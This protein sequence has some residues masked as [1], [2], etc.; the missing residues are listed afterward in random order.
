MT[1]RRICFIVRPALERLKKQNDR[2]SSNP[3]HGCR[4]FCAGSTSR[5]GIGFS[6]MS[7]NN[8]LP[9][10][11]RHGD[12][13]RGQHAPEWDRWVAMISRCTNPKQS[14]YPRYGGRGI[15]V[16][17]RWLNS[18]E[19]FLSDMGR[20]PTP[21][22]SI[23][24]INNDGNYEPGNCRW[25][26]RFEQQNNRRNTMVIEHDGKKLTAK[27]WSAATGIP[28]QRIQHRI[29]H[30]WPIPEALSAPATKQNRKHYAI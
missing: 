12:A 3:R 26:T 23:D 13:A 25:V 9:R 8:G 21:E 2:S 20:I 6:S 18:Y 29:K 7:Y 30:G 28:S 1:P 10:K 15:R 11:N 17:D 4:S 24:R 22:H 14:N 27:E 19:D 5:V 16:C